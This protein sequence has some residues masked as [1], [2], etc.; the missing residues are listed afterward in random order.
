MAPSTDNPADDAQLDITDFE[1]DWEARREGVSRAWR[2]GGAE[3]GAARGG[4]A[5]GR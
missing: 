3:R 5:T 4:G 2:E 1:R